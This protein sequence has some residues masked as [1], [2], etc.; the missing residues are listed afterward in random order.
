MVK[1]LRYIYCDHPECSTEPR[2]V[3]PQIGGGAGRGGR[4]MIRSP[5]VV[6]RDVPTFSSASVARFVEEHNAKP[7]DPDKDGRIVI[8]RSD[9]VNEDEWK[10]SLAVAYRKSLA[11][12]NRPETFP[13]SVV[14][15]DGKFECKSC[16]TRCPDDELAGYLEVRMEMGWVMGIVCRSCAGD[17]E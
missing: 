16:R 17:S 7:F 3:A 2:E 9:A 1:T 4:A 6:I 12:G 11:E 15:P 10:T 8:P 13:I 5:F 14:T